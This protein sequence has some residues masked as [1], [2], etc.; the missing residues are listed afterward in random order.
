[1]LLAA[2]GIPWVNG[3][4]GAGW[5]HGLKVVAVAVVAQGSLVDGNKALHGLGS[6]SRLLLR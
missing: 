5:L 1:M 4:Q 6:L 2:D 3:E